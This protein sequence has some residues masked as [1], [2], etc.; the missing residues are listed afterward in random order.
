[1]GWKVLRAVTA[2]DAIEH[3]EQANPQII[4]LDLVMQEMDSLDLVERLRERT[5]WQEIP[6]ILLTPRDLDQEDRVR[7][8]GSVERVIQ[9]AAMTPEALLEEI[10]LRIEESVGNT[11]AREVEG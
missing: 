9:R 4:I 3:L 10:H 11:G 2:P 7:L 5:E 1:D 6:L 8:D